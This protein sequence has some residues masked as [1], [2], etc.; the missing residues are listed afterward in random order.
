[1]K[2]SFGL[3][4][5]HGT[6]IIHKNNHLTRVNG[7]WQIKINKLQTKKNLTRVQNCSELAG[8]YR[9]LVPLSLLRMH[10]K[11]CQRRT[12]EFIQNVKHWKV[13]DYRNSNLIYLRVGFRSLFLTTCFQRR[14]RQESVKSQNDDEM[15]DVFKFHDLKKSG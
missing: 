13:A 14:R 4:V 8:K 3:L 11:I 1:M 10:K 5:G 6:T 12:T 15:V 9:N 7:I 2:C